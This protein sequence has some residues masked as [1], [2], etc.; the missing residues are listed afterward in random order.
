MVENIKI[1]DVLNNIY[2]KEDVEKLNFIFKEA[3]NDEELKKNFLSF[4]KKNEDRIYFTLINVEINNELL[5]DVKEEFKNTKWKHIMDNV[6]HHYDVNV[7][8]YMLKELS[9]AKTDIF[10]DW[11]IDMMKD[12]HWEVKKEIAH[13]YSK[14][15]TDNTIN[16]LVSFLDDSDRRVV[17]EAISLLSYKGEAIF[18]YIEKY[19]QLPMIRLKLNILELLN[20]IDTIKK[21]K[22]LLELS[23]DTKE[24]VKIEAQQSIFMFLEKIDIDAMNG[25]AEKVLDYLEE[26]LNKND[27]KK[28]PIII[29]MLLKFKKSGAEKIVNDIIDKLNI[30]D[31]YLRLLE[32]V[33]SKEKIYLVI[34]M[35]SSKI[36]EVKNM[37][38]RLLNNFKI[39]KDFEEDIE[40]VMGQYILENIS[41]FTPK[42]RSSIISFIVS[43]NILEKNIM[44]LNS[45]SSQERKLAVEIIGMIGEPRIYK[46]LLNMRKDPDI[47]VRMCVLKVLSSQKDEKFLKFY[48]EMLEDP[49]EIIQKEAIESI[50]MLNTEDSKKALYNAMNHTNSY[51]RNYVSKILAK[52]TITKY[53]AS[54]DKLDEANKK[55]VALMLEKMES[56]IEEVF[57]KKMKSVDVNERRKVVEI[58]EYVNNKSDYNQIILAAMKDPEANIRARISAILKNIKDKEVL[59]GMLKLLNDPDKRV[60]ANIIEAFGNMNN[61]TAVKLMLPYL[62]DSDNRI[63]ANAI[64]ALYHIGYKKAL[65]KIEEMIHDKSEKMR[66]SAV[67]V[68][69]TLKLYDKKNEMDSL[70]MDKSEIVKINLI[71]LFYEFGEVHKIQAFLQDRDT[72]VSEMAREYYNKGL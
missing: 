30:K 36:A 35:L 26:E 38:L 7:R 25:D 28:L 22:Y 53:I 71:K 10:L 6:M 60:R 3:S 33:K 61:K 9:K 64:I 20:K 21:L 45:E 65:L 31:N 13:I 49:E 72:K 12:E 17:K 16:L 24:K 19:M 1:E 40:F 41:L 59:L 50:A 37:G 51:I 43:N 56:D 23:K 42:E 70:M 32:E 5:S 69:R 27:I 14:Y 46:L 48:V 4:L 11:Y 47:E 54:F 63:K 8:I 15:N 58:L 34:E 29:K 2:L 55:R 62:E 68:I 57:L 66:A 44:K 39:N 67:Y 18:E 52:E